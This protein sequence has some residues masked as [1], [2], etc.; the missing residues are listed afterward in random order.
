MLLIDAGNTRIK[1]RLCDHTG[2]HLAADAMPVDADAPPSGWSQSGV[3]S[4][5]LGVCVA[6]EAVRQRIECWL[7][8]LGTGIDWLQATARQGDLENGY[9]EPSQLGADRWAALLGARQHHRDRS[10]LVVMAGTATTVDLLQ[11]DGRF[12]GGLILPGQTTLRASLY[13]ATANLPVAEGAFVALPDHTDAAIATGCLLAQAGAINQ[14]YR[15]HQ[16]T[17]Q[18]TGCLLSGGDAETLQPLLE[19]PCERMENLV[20]DGLAAL[21]GVGK[22][23]PPAL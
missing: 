4:V 11:A 14:F 13:R 2:Q 1:W 12:A 21:A 6:G 19:M 10:L 16:P 8:A 18:L 15:L 5:A 17:C 20:L 3:A 23:C 7:T 9:R 22:L